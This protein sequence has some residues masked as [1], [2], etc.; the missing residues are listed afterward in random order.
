MND[1]QLSAIN[2]SVER[3]LT[4]DDLDEEFYEILRRKLKMDVKESKLSED[5]QDDDLEKPD[6]K[7]D[8]RDENEE[9]IRSG[10]AKIDEKEEVV[11]ENEAS[12]NL[13]PSKEAVLN[14]QGEVG[15]D[16]QASVTERDDKTEQITK[17][18]TSGKIQL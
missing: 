11:K 17:F 1:P 8:Q 9:H 7:P 6:V 4:F 13:L 18:P 12:V 5:A 10:K 14:V 2:I 3:N 16:S 15:D